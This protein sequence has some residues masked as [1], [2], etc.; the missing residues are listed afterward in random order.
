MKVVPD[1]F[2]K[3]KYLKN[4]YNTNNNTSNKKFPFVK[5]ILDLAYDNSD[6][7]D[8]IIHSETDIIL[9]PYFYD[10]VSDLINDG[11]DSII[12]NSRNVSNKYSDIQSLSRIW[13]EVGVPNI[14]WDCFIFKKELYDKF[15]LGDGIVG[16]NSIGKILYINLR[17]FSQK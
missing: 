12:I 7:N 5:D 17:N 1:H 8:F 14:G 10:S 13:S 6:Q 2:I 3:L 11:Y 9:S 16:V 15:M 4:F